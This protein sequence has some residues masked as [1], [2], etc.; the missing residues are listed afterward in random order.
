MPPP[1]IPPILAIPWLLAT[2]AATA[3]A[4]SSP[5]SVMPGSVLLHDFSR[6]DGPRPRSP[7]DAERDA[8]VERFPNPRAAPGAICD[9]NWPGTPPAQRTG[10]RLLSTVT[11]AEGSFTTRSAPQVAYVVDYCSTGAG[12]P[13]YWRALVLE[14]AAVKLDL[15]L[16]PLVAA[17][18]LDVELL[19]AVDVDGDGHLELLL[20][21]RHFR[22]QKGSSEAVLV[23]LAP[24]APARLGR[25]P[26]VERYCDSGPER[27]ARRI[28]RHSKGGVMSFSDEVVRVECHYPPAPP[29]RQ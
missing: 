12:M 13:R 15:D 7:A 26:A 17:D 14:G 20:E 22:R 29:R 1:F 24:G 25:W 21:T 9:P 6:E 27:V 18:T 3:A 28:F 16:A 19:R 11:K 23:R 10:G 8:L 4:D 5:P 2:G